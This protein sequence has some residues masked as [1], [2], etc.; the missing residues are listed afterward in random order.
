MQMKLKE[1]RFVFDE[2][3]RVQGRPSLTFENRQAKAALAAQRAPQT[4][5]GNL[6]ATEVAGTS[7]NGLAGL[8]DLVMVVE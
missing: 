8:G 2:A 4:A 5:V 1:V 7:V 3:D 6:R